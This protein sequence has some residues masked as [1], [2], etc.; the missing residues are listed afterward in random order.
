VIENSA[1][2]LGLVSQYIIL[3]PVKNYKGR[4]GEPTNRILAVF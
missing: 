3:A 2:Q 1:E 4:A